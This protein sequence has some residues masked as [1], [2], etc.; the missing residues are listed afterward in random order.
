MGIMFNLKKKRK[1]RRVPYSLMIYHCSHS[2]QSHHTRVKINNWT[3]KSVTHVSA[4]FNAMRS[5][6]HLCSATRVF[7]F[8]TF[9]FTYASKVVILCRLDL[10]NGESENTRSN[11]RWKCQDRTCTFCFLILRRSFRSYTGSSKKRRFSMYFVLLN[12]GDN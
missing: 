7:F 4:F 2:L 6:E 1:H 3:R 8:F 12:F 5:I 10:M 9:F 11:A